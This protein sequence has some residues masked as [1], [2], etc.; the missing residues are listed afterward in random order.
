MTI[1]SLIAALDEHGGLG[2][3]NQLLCHLPADLQHFKKLTMGKPIM[4]GRRTFESIGKPLPNR[5]NIVI[6]TTMDSL[7][8]VSVYASLS[9]ALR[10]TSE[11]IEIMIIG[12]ARLFQEGLP[13]AQHLYLTKIHHQFKA[14]VFFPSFSEQD[15][16]VESSEF[17]PHDAKNPYDM[18]FCHLIKKH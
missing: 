15:W 11:A 8:G 10:A 5:L 2:K 17:Y 18:T 16:M 7:P 4:M 6:S 3:N 1:I 12:G 13:I 14:D 9:D